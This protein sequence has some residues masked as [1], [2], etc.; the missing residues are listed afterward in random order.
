METE[1][2]MRYP[3]TNYQDL[4]VP[5]LK[6]LCRHY[7]L[8]V[9]GTKNIVMDIERVYLKAS[10]DDEGAFTD[11]SHNQI[12]PDHAIDKRKSNDINAS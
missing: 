3:E 5:K 12:S 10:N 2:S 4:T 1:D 11:D 6:E 7:L 9:T 8:K